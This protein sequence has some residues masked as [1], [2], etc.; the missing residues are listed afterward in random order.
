M[1]NRLILTYNN[2]V[3]SDTKEREMQEHQHQLFES[4]QREGAKKYA[5]GKTQ[6][7]E[8][9]SRQ[10]KKFQSYVREDQMPVATKN[11]VIDNNL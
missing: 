10:F 7:D 2:G 4:L 6:V 1:K 9:K 11:Q 8:T 3:K 5:E